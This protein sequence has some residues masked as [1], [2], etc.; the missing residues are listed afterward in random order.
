MILLT[1][2]A[3]SFG[4]AL[5]ATVGVEAAAL[6]FRPIDG[7][8]PAV[9]ALAPDSEIEAFALAAASSTAVVATASAIR[10]AQGSGEPR[11]VPLSGKV[12]GL[13]VLRDGSACYAVVRVSGRKGALRS[14]D[15]VRLDL[16]TA[17]VSSVAT[18]PT[19]AAGLALTG[20][21][22]TLL[23]ASKDEVRT[24]SIPTVASG[25][26]YRVIGDNVGVS[27]IDG[28]SFAVV[29]QRSRVALVDLA[30][31]QG[32]DGLELREEAI[33][34]AP[35]LGLSA[36]AGEGG[37]VAL[38]EGGQAW[39]VH[40]GSCPRFRRR[41]ATPASRSCGARDDRRRCSIRVAPAASSAI[42]PSR[43][44]WSPRATSPATREPFRDC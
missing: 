31:T 23:V 43:A 2:R 11:T 17:R 5:A 39:R 41:A 6:E 13:A 36:S 21:D 38:A 44:R 40:V 29:A 42:S 37:P 20:D 24:F 14:V 18:L 26:L 8:P 15:L 19:T 35:I 25:R 12:A 9:S 4:I 16:R 34:P 30:A 1:A 10:Y 33:A 28:T 27:P 22:A 7:N 3:A 32:R